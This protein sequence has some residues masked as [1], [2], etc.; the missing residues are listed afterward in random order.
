MTE[1]FLFAQ[2]EIDIATAP[3]LRA[4]LQRAIASGSDD[5]VLDCH[6][7][8][9]M[10]C[11]GIRVLMEALSDLEAR[12][13]DLVVTNPAPAIQRVLDIVGL[14]DPLHVQE[15][16]VPPA[17]RGHAQTSMA[18]MLPSARSGGSR[19]S[20]HRQGVDC[21][22]SHRRSSRAPGMGHHHD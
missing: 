9:F 22:T 5:V 15:R 11:A 2:G 13:R 7:L 14:T 17:L 12:G 3:D 1:H 8:T 4:D 21:G 16:A 10:D 18:A 6:G 19:T 20:L